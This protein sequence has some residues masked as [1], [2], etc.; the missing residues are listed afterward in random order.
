MNNLRKA[1]DAAERVTP[2]RMW[3]FPTYAALLFG[4]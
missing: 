1:A 3:P 2:S 4:V